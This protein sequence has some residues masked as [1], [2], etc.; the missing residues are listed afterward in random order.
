M[1]E[2]E[3]TAPEFAPGLRY[4]PSPAP[5]YPFAPQ[6]SDRSPFPADVAAGTVGGRAVGEGPKNPVVHLLASLLV[7]GLGTF[8]NGDL[9]RGMVIFAAYVS[10]WI[11][12][13]L[14][15]WILVGVLFLPVALGIWVFGMYDA[16]RGAETWNRRLGE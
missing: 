3:S 16:Y 5:A 13:L 6:S 12:Y 8:L 2:H 10:C 1:T 11:G 14:L 15:V 7:P 9:T 4:E